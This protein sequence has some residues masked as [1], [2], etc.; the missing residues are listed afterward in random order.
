V[1]DDS[2][3]SGRSIRDLRIRRETGA[4]IVALRKADGS[5]DTTPSPDVRFA[6]GDFLIA[7]GTESETTK[8]FWVPLHR[9]TTRMKSSGR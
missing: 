3:Q 5:F 1:R 7:I 2:Q 4:V 6:S 9:T 8:I